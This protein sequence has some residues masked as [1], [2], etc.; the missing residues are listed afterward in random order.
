V[1]E[2]K[3]RTHYDLLGVSF[4]A[5]EDDLRRG[6]ESALRRAENIGY[7]VEPN[8]TELAQIAEKR[9]QIMFAY[10]MLKDPARR[11]KYNAAIATQLA[12][13]SESAIDGVTAIKPNSNSN[14]NQSS[15]PAAFNVASGSAQSTA[16]VM[17]ATVAQSNISKSASPQSSGF[18]KPEV[19]DLRASMQE[20]AAAG[21]SL[22]DSRNGS[23]DE[24]EYAHLGVRFTAMMIDGY[25][26]IALFFLFLLITS[27]SISSGRSGGLSMFAFLILSLLT[28]AYYVVGESGKHRATWGKRWMGLQ[29]MRSDGDES[30]SGMRAFSRYLLRSL[31]ANLFMVGYIMAFFT[32]RK[33]ALH[34]L[35][36][37]S[38]VL[39]AK[40]PPKHW[41]LLC[42][43]L[44]L[45]LP[46]LG[47][48]AISTN[49][50]KGSNGA[51]AAAIAAENRVDP[52][53]AT[54]RRSEVE[55]AYAA[56]TSLQR[57]LTSHLSANGKWPTEKE[58]S[59]VISQS[60][61]S[62]TLREHEVKLMTDGSFMLSLGA[63]A[64]GTARMVFISNAS[65]TNAQWNCLPINID[66]E[67]TVPQCKLE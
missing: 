6:C 13:P 21:I 7:G 64:E 34:D 15:T 49:V 40:E 35:I 41:L 57:S 46:A 1:S 26:L 22:G 18:V 27:A 30:L 23:Y 45:L 50:V 61:R 37:D 66:E 42:I 9:K 20:R 52:K 63:T 58:T 31:S 2:T 19:V 60:S 10:A 51:L 3:Q 36:T 55:T 59:D 12:R 17:S 43:G 28:I 32:E 54:P 16:M 62:E 48:I 44:T 29:V 11:A 65:A 24:R 47:L 25:V 39:R 67:E 38:V 5:S 53:R 56:A 14:S 33:Q 4:Y 8:A